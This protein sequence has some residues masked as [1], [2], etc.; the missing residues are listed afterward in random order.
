MMT[1]FRT[2][3]CIVMIVLIVLA[4]AHT[5]QAQTLPPPAV[6]AA[7]TEIFG[8]YLGIASG[9]DAGGLIGVRFTVWPTSFL[10]VWAGAGWALIKPSYN[11]G[12]ELRLP[13]NGRVSP[14]VVAMT[15][16]NAIIKIQGADQ[17]NNIFFGPTVGAGLMVQRKR[18]TN[19]WRFSVNLPF[20]STEMIDYYE[21][22][23]QR[24]DIEFTQALVPFTVGIGYHFSLS[25]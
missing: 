13:T 14:F 17:L 4:T 23:K 15:G 5:C 25:N 18:G 19:Y 12:L 22:L 11:A 16:Y 24:P 20:R 8:P 3:L 7:V 21:S 1:Y 10:S 6:K 2:L 9:Q